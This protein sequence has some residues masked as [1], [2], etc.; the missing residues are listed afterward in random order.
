MGI[1]GTDVSKESADIVLTDDNFASVAAAVEEGRRVYDNLIKVL[2]YLLP[3]NIGEAQIAAVTTVI[4]FQIFYLFNCRSLEN[5][6][7]SIGLRTNPWIYAGIG[8]LLALQI[9]FV[10]LPFMNAL[11]DSAPLS[12]G[13]WIGSLAVGFIV[14]PVIGTEKW[15]RKRRH[16]KTREGGNPA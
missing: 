16:A 12:A 2:A 13:N 5:S 11:F 6:V 8:A 15:W 1:T 7:L 10:Y 9:G 3:T 4:L 14:I